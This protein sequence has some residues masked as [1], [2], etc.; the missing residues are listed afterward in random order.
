MVASAATVHMPVVEKPRYLEWGPVV[1]GAVGAA[2]ISLLLL[3][4]GT[5][6]GLSVTSPW[7]DRGTSLTAA[8]WV[9]VW[10]TVIVQIGSFAAGA[11]LAGRMRSQWGDSAT[12]EGQFR[13]S[14]HGFMV[15][16]LGV[17]IGATV[18]ALTS[19]SV[20]RTATQ[21]ASVV[22]AGAASGTAANP[23]SSGTAPTDYAVDLLL[24]PTP[25]AASTSVAEP[26]RADDTMLRTE[27]GRI[28]AASIKNREFSPRDRD[29]LTQVVMTRTGLPEAE[30]Q[31]RV[32]AAMNEARDLE[33]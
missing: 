20:L 12:E 16:A 24:R 19:G 10:W 29:Y 18:L 33:D 15:W 28:F 17:L 7:P 1:G 2:A 11:Y 6:V 27:A 23:G 9:V 14:T 32:D 26:S 4:F 22:A 21:S 3:T 13:D 8:A 25:R 30:A 5:A 31:Q